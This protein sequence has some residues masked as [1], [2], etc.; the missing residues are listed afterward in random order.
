MAENGLN[1]R[2]VQYFKK[3]IFG[4]FHEKNYEESALYLHLH[5]FSAILESE[6]GQKWHKMDKKNNP[7]FFGHSSIFHNIS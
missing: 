4:R 1:G 7:F 3:P 6:N 2:F 5:I